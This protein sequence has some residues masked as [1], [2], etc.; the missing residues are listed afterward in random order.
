MEAKAFA[1]YIHT[2]PTKLRRVADAIRGQ[3]VPLAQATLKYLPGPTARTMAKVIASAVANADDVHG[4]EAD[5]LYVAQ[6]A[7]DDA[8]RTRNTRGWR[9]GARGR[10]KPMRRRSSH[11]SVVLRA[12]EEA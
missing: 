12:V 8:G 10:G 9:P 2:S 11:I 3:P 5:E 4:L 1:R 6:I 7:V